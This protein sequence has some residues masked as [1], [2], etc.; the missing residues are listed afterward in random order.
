MYWTHLYESPETFIQLYHDRGNSEQFH[1]ELKSDMAFE[2][3]PSGKMDV[4]AILLPIAMIV[5]N[6]LRRIGQ[7]ALTMVLQLCCEADKTWTK[8]NGYK[9]IPKLAQGVFCK[10]GNFIEGGT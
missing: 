3:F 1:S 9:S 6:T 5:F 8:I 10:D 4:N 2:R 7:A